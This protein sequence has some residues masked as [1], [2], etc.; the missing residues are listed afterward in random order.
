MIGL[1]TDDNNSFHMYLYSR[2]LFDTKQIPEIMNLNVILYP[3]FLFLALP[4]GNLHNFILSTEKEAE[5]PIHEAALQKS[6]K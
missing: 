3:Y 4:P 1:F 5:A 6:L 2:K